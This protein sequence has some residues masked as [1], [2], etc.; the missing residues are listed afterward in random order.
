V[1]AQVV[2]HAPQ[3][4]A[5]L[6]RSTQTPEHDEVPASQ[7]AA[8]GGGLPTIELPLHESSSVANIKSPDN[9]RADQA[10][11]TSVRALTGRG[12]ATP[13]DR[14]RAKRESVRGACA[15]PDYDEK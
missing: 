1:A 12:G 7:L 15:K 2:P 5:E 3:F 13:P 14:E 10:M 9:H 11:R 8:G 6:C 4:V